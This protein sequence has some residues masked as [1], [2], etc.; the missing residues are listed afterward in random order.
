MHLLL[1]SI[2]CT[3]I[4]T[5]IKHARTNAGTHSLTH[6]SQA[7]LEV[8]HRHLKANLDALEQSLA[9]ANVE[10]K[11]AEHTSTEKTQRIEALESQLHQVEGLLAK[12]SKEVEHGRAATARAE[13]KVLEA[14][15][16]ADQTRGK[17]SDAQL[18]A[19]Q[20]AVAWC[21]SAAY[22]H[23][24]RVGCFTGITWAEHERVSWCRA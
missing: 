4:S 21:V 7:A 12:S 23:W 20:A 16:V 2:Y 13:A 3:K 14:C 22:A 10:L 6:A 9:K 11:Q 5:C 24:K 8:E 15:S 19:H 17:L 18:S 1:A